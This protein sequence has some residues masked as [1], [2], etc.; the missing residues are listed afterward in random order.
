MRDYPGKVTLK[1]FLFFGLITITEQQFNIR[2]NRL[3]RTG[4][5]NRVGG[6]EF[7]SRVRRSCE[8]LL[9]VVKILCS[10][11]IISNSSQSGYHLNK[12]QKLY[13]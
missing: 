11:I 6:E 3:L 9:N 2:G 7:V 4:V 8:G 12:G 13:H 10:L 5:V 1:A